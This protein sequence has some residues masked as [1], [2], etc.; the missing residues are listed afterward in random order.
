MSKFPFFPTQ[1]IENPPPYIVQL[2]PNIMS[3]PPPLKIVS[4]SSTIEVHIQKIIFFS[5]TSMIYEEC[6]VQGKTMKDEDKG[7]NSEEYI[8]E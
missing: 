1:N 2:C 3:H 7:Q 6:R 8:D 4:E 5:E